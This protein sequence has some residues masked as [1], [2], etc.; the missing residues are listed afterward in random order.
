LDAHA[1]DQ[2]PTAT[3]V[4]GGFQRRGE[5]G[6]DLF[7]RLGRVRQDEGASDQFKP[8]RI[9][10]TIEEGIERRDGHRRRQGI[11]E[12]SKS[13]HQTHPR[14]SEAITRGRP[15][16]PA[17]EVQGLGR[18]PY[19]DPESGHV[20]KAPEAPRMAMGGLS[21]PVAGWVARTAFG[22]W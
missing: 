14:P 10:L 18:V 12:Y 20:R 6:H 13:S 9:S 7:V 15:T 21:V 1:A 8:A 11:G 2:G 3:S 5:I 17:G 4:Q 16:P 19:P 22:S